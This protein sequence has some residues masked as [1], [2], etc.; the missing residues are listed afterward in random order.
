MPP[1]IRPDPDYRRP[2]GR[3]FL[4]AWSVFV[5]GFLCGAVSA[6]TTWLIV[7]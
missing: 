1:L 6:T 5:L 3:A 7:R 4:A 2:T